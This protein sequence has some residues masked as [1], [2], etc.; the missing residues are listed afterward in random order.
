LSDKKGISPMKACAT[1]PN[2]FLPEQ[3]EKKAEEGLANPDVPGKR[4]GGENAI[5]KTSLNTLSLN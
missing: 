3:L 5:T 1:Y 4:P 2:G